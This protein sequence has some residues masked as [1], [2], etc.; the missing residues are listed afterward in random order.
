M[1]MRNEFGKL[2]TLTVKGYKSIEEVNRLELYDIN[3]I[4]GPNG[5]GKSNFVSLF[6]FLA[7]LARE[8]LQD[9]VTKQGGLNKILH[10]GPK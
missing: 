1:V 6:H 7:R 5:V 10:F 2:Q 3:I 4:I 8:E 9:H